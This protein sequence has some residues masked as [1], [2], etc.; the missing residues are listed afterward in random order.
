MKIDDDEIQN[1]EKSEK[2]KSMKHNVKLD[3]V[4]KAACGV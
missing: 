2:S 3:N 1:S 4:S